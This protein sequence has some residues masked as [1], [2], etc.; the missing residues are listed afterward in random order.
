MLVNFRG[1][2]TL[3]YCSIGILPYRSLLL[4]YGFGISNTAIRSRLHICAFSVI[5]LLQCSSKEFIFKKK[6]L[7]LFHILYIIHKFSLDFLYYIYF[8]FGLFVII[9][10]SNKIHFK[11]KT[12]NLVK[13][14]E[15]YQK[16]THSFRW[17]VQF[18]IIHSLL[19]IPFVFHYHLIL[20]ATSI[21]GY[22]TYSFSNTWIVFLIRISRKNSK[23]IIFV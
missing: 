15:S 21:F 19:N 18:Y 11:L 8:I 3:I 23:W 5:D 9:R 7:R 4:K 10:M 14:R 13:T 2:N 6:C 1:A 20:L 12:T 22:I 16:Y 17:I